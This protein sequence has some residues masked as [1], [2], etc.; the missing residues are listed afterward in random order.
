MLAPH[1]ISCLTSFSQAHCI[2][3]RTVVECEEGAVVGR[4]VVLGLCSQDNL[5]SLF[6]LQCCSAG[7]PCSP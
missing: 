3:A 6:C 4:I 2:T 5:Y 7:K 1:A